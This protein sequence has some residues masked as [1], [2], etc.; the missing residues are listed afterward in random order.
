VVSD[1]WTGGAGMATVA[2]T[3]PSARAKK[4]TDA[5]AAKVIRALAEEEV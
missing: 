1:G 4:I 3:P 5:I 2:M